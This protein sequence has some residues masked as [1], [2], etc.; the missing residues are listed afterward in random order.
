M[1]G[2]HAS[3]SPDVLARYAADAALEV[4]GVHSLVASH[5]PR[6][7]PVRVAV[8]DDRTASVELHVVAAWGAS[9]G[10]VGLDVQARVAE[11]L[12]RMTDLR[13]A[14]VDVSVDEVGPVPV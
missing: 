4:D 2:G 7:R 9:F 1:E 10:S 6:H 13:P 3:I 11:Y 12:A 8:A 14:R 5:L